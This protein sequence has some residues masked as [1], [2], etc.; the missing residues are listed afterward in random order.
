MQKYVQILVRSQFLFQ[1]VNS[2][3]RAQL[4]ENCEFQGTNNIQGQILQTFLCQMEV[5]V[6]SILQMFIA[7][8]K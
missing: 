7:T 5:I 2:F 3:L 4:K 1:E 6:F 8:H